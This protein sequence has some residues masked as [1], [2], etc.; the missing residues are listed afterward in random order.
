VRYLGLIWRIPLALL[1][2]SVFLVC[3]LPL[4]LVGFEP[5]RRREQEQDS[6]PV[7]GAETGVDDDDDDPDRRRW[8][9]D[10]RDHENYARLGKAMAENSHEPTVPVQVWRAERAARRGNRG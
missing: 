9:R 8:K 4:V 7:E 2:L 1:R 10:R 3:V 5:P 6:K